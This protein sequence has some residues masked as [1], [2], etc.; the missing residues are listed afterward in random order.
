MTRPTSPKDC[1]LCL[2]QKCK[3]TPWKQGVYL[4]FYN[5]D[6][7]LHFKK[8]NYFNFIIESFIPHG[9]LHPYSNSICLHLCKCHIRE[10]T[11]EGNSQALYTLLLA[12]LNMFFWFG[13]RRRI[14]PEAVAI[15]SCRKTD[16]DTCVHPHGITPDSRVGQVLT[17][18]QWSALMTIDNNLSLFDFQPN[19]LLERGNHSLKTASN[20]W[21]GRNKALIKYQSF[22]SQYIY[23]HPYSALSVNPTSY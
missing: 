17:Q 4:C 11:K 7:N 15:L 8:K 6:R 14:L 20:K 13:Y 21:S 22:C 3:W 23:M 12:F 16:V 1:S 10:R 2:W 18:G 9:C 19:S 5:L